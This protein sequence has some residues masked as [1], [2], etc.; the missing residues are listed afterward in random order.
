MVKKP[1]RE[2]MDTRLYEEII[3]LLDE[4]SQD[5]TIPKNVRK[6]AIDSKTRL[7]NQKDRFDLRCATAASILDDMANDPNV[8]AHGRTALYTVISKLEALAKS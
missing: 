6:S 7:N 1:E 3:Y 4:M 2:N 8:P 5:V